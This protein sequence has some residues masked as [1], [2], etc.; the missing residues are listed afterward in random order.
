MLTLLHNI[1][2]SAIPNPFAFLDYNVTFLYRRTT[3]DFFNQSIVY[4]FD[5]IASWSFEPALIYLDTVISAIAMPEF[6]TEWTIGAMSIPDLLAR[7]YSI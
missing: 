6:M 7:G 1:S 5:P 4:H 2:Q 3:F